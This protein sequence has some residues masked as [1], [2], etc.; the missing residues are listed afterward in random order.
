SA[1]YAIAKT[2]FGATSKNPNWNDNVDF[3]RDGIINSA[4][5]A[6]I[7]RNMAKIGDSGLWVSQIPASGS[8]T[9]NINSPAGSPRPGYW[10]WVPG[11]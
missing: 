1:D 3:N 8:A 10:L 6:I 7:I 9:L 11:F 4:D 5:I 2:A